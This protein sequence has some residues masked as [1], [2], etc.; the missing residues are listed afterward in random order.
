MHVHV[1]YTKKAVMFGRMAILGCWTAGSVYESAKRSPVYYTE[2][3][4]TW[5]LSA[6][7]HMYTYLHVR[8]YMYV[9]DLPVNQTTY[10]HVYMFL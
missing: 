10:M 7:L 3:F 2:Q 4:N 8:I 6:C 1:H 9:R 5:N